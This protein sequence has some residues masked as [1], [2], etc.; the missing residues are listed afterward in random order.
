MRLIVRL[1]VV[2][3]LGLTTSLLGFSQ[4]PPDSAADGHNP[5]GAQGP[6]GTNDI[7]HVDPITGALTVQIAVP[8]LPV[9]GR[10]PIYPHLFKY[11]SGSTITFQAEGVYTT[12]GQT[13]G[14]DG[15]YVCGQVGN[16]GENC[17]QSP[18]PAIPAPDPPTI[19]QNYGWLGANNSYNQTFGPVGPWIVVNGPL[20]YNYSYYIQNQTVQYPYN[21]GIYTY[22][23]CSVTG[24]YIF[25]DPSGNSHDLNLSTNVSLNNTGSVSQFV[26]DAPACSSEY[27]PQAP[28]SD[29]SDGSVIHAT[30]NDHAVEL[31][32]PDGTQLLPNGNLED[33]N[34]NIH[35]STTDSLGRTSDFSS[36]SDAGGMI[37]PFGNF[38]MP[39]PTNSDLQITSFCVASI[40][41]PTQYSILS[42]S[43]SV[44]ALTSIS[45]PDGTSYQFKYDPVYA[46]IS[47]IIFPTGGYVQ[48]T[49]SIKPVAEMTLGVTRESALVVTSACTSNDS[50][51]TDC[52]TYTYPQN[53]DT[54]QYKSKVTA[55]D[56]SYTNYTGIGVNLSSTFKNGA[57]SI[58]ETE[59]DIYDKAGNE[60]MSVVTTSPPFTSYITTTYWDSKTYNQQQVHYLYDQYNNVIEKDESD[61]LTCS[62]ATPCT[63]PIPWLR[64]TFTSYAYATSNPLFLTAHIVNKPYLVMVTDG[65]GYPY[66]LTQY[67][68]DEFPVT[69]STGYTNHDDAKYGISSLLPRGNLTT[70]SHCAGLNQ[71]TPYSTAN[72]NACP[73]S[74]W[75]KT[76]HTY[77]L[78][79]QV[80]STKD[81]KGNTTTF[82]YADNYVGATAPSGISTNGYVTT[83]TQ[84]SPYGYTDKYSYD[85]NLGKPITHRDWNNKTTSYSYNDPLNRI[86][87]IKYPDNGDVQINYINAGISS[88]GNLETPASVQLLTATGEASGSIQKTTVYDGL[89]RKIQ[90]QLNSDPY[91]TDY[92]DTTY[93]SMGHVQSFS[94]PYRS[95]SDPTYGITSYFYDA[96]GRMT[97]KVDSD[98]SS[99]QYWCY[100]GYAIGNP[101]YCK[102]HTGSKNGI[103]TDFQDENGNRWQRTSNGL[104][105]MVEVSEPNGANASASMETDYAY[106][107]LSDLLSVVQN[108]VSGTDTPRITR[109][110]SYDSLSRLSTANNPETGSV[111]YLY[112]ANSNLSSKTDARGI[113]TSYGYDALNRIVSK[114]YSNDSSGTPISCFQYDTSS[115]LNAASGATGNML[116][117]LSNAWTQAANTSC[118]GTSPNYA[119][120]TGSY[121]SLKSILWY[122]PMGR[123][124][125]TNQQQCVGSHCSTPSPFQLSMFYDLVGT[126][127][128]LTNWSG[129]PGQSMA[130]TNYYDGA[131]RPCLTTVTTSNSSWNS[132][133]PANLFQTNPSTTTPGYTPFGGLQNWSMGSTSSTASTGCGTPSST[134]NVTQGYTNRLWMNS[135]S[136]TG[137]IP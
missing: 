70:E 14:N 79:G 7:W 15:N 19:Q 82:S 133:F 113:T 29:T 110:F 117:R 35:T 83:V 71:S 6:L 84:P 114:T 130:L 136:A 56:G 106:N 16:Y 101:T 46:T 109:S 55:P 17:T 97:S 53:T 115:I 85:Y 76:T 39:Y 40:S 48:F 30:V 18:G 69:G 81:P 12:S 78:T 52:W 127:T 108:G 59:R 33:S 38:S 32:M 80:L 77:D 68:Y 11:N 75:V 137:Q 5:A 60:L 10:G 45:L 94:N 102:A 54:P 36:T 31:V 49:W 50:G 21:S 100:N 93:D 37:L 111:I 128:G 122:D 107:P 2:F 66:S 89:A 23:G 62:T 41:C 9:G 112:D 126:L 28:I 4:G 22:Y 44:S 119:P 34:G 24:P 98:G 13:I 61:F 95:K 132:N 47:E 99:T 129:G 123:P 96:L 103:W 116:G 124:K 104:G 74:A 120:A 86:K 92:V 57:P 51:G 131:S 58:F 26:L 8:P 90:T 64:K 27:Y 20:L 67:G 87:E 73:A 72:A 1:T 91:G 135:I 42:P 3:I 25:I 125:N 65:N 118:T 88:T 105:Q 121:L 43:G 63:G 134:I